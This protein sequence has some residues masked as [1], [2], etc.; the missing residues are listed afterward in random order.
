MTYD[1][2]LEGVRPMKRFL[3]ISVA[4]LAFACGSNGGGGDTDGPPG[5]GDGNNGPDSDPNAPDAGIG[6]DAFGPPNCMAGGTQCSNCI[7]DDGD[8]RIDG[9]DPECTG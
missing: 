6:P 8:G 2:K 1:H 3:L 4:T 5:G 9:F 7:D